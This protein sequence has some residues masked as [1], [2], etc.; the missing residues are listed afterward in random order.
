VSWKSKSW[1][2][3]EPSQ[4]TWPSSPIVRSSSPSHAL[5]GDGVIVYGVSQPSARF[6][7][8]IGG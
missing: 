5:I 8:D 7:S 6:S 3:R 2:S 4:S 1:P